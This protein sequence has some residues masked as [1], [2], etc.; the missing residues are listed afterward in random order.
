MS[1]YT[2]E[3]HGHQAHQLSVACSMEKSVTE[4]HVAY[5]FSKCLSLFFEAG[6]RGAVLLASMI[7]FRV[8]LLA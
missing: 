6:N 4:E 2:N 8:L 3:I 1:R 7:H 5:L